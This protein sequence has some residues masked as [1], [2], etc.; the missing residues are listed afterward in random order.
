MFWP[1]ISPLLLTIKPAKFLKYRKLFLTSADGVALSDDDGGHDLLS[2]FSFSPNR[3][4][5]L[6]SSQVVILLL[7]VAKKKVGPSSSLR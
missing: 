7:W 5:F 2:Q 6:A 1:F 3:L 4:L